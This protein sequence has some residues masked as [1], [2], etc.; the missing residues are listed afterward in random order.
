VEQVLKSALTRIKTLLLEV[1]LLLYSR[2]LVIIR[3]T[4]TIY[5]ELIRQVLLQQTTEY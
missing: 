5:L 3:R 2:I 1:L 4:I